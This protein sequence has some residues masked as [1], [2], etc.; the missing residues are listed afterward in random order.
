M[1]HA[2]QLKLTVQP[3][4]DAIHLKVVLMTVPLLGIHLSISACTY[5]QNQ[6]VSEYLPV[7]SLS[8]D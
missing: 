7:K 2:A 8:I 1:H 5:S 3:I 4:Q 6:L